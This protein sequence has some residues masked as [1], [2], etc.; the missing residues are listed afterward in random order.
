M[1]TQPNNMYAIKLMTLLEDV[2]PVFAELEKILADSRKLKSK[3]KNHLNHL[4]LYYK[5]DRL[6]EESNPITE[7]I[8]VQ[9][10]EHICLVLEGI[11]KIMTEI[12]SD[13]E[14]SKLYIQSGVMD[15]LQEISQKLSKLIS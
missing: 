13:E 7:E 1:N 15:K 14:E 2:S 11:G 3:Y 5:V 12:S 4:S 10:V 9:K 8:L 6:K